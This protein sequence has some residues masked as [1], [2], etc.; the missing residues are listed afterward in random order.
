MIL[1][2]PEHVAPILAGTKTQ[3]RRL[4]ERRW[5]VGA[6]H[7]CYTKPPFAKGG[8]EPFCRVRV[9]DV[10]TDILAD[11]SESDARAEG[12]LDRRSFL[13]AFFRINPTAS[14]GLRV[15]VVEFEVMR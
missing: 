10:H 6:V 11:I 3:T 14:G 13:R 7:K 4:G 9:L 8:A 1:F 2:K 5:N 15:W 12:C